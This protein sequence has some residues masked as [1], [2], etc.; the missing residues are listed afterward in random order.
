MWQS[1]ASKQ[2][3]PATLEVI[4]L[5]HKIVQGAALPSELLSR[6]RLS[7]FKSVS[8]SAQAGTVRQPS[9]AMTL[10]NN[11]GIKQGVCVG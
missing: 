11:H 9:L 3:N 10:G 4:Y 7:L 6:P 5:F 2:D 1:I 8:Q